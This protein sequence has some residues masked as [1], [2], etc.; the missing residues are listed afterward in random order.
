MPAVPG[1]AR[2]VACEAFFG[3][4]FFGVRFVGPDPATSVT[5]FAHALAG[6]DFFPAVVRDLGLPLAQRFTYAEVGAEG[7]WRS[8]GAF[9]IADPAHPD[10]AVLMGSPV[11]HDTRHNKALEFS[12]DNGDGTTHWFALP[13]GRELTRT[14]VAEVLRQAHA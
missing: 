1:S 2:D 10:W 12:F 8:V 14:R 3:E 13:L 6:P 4:A 11:W 7:A 5:S 9:R